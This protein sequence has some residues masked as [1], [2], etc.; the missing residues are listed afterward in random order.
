MNYTKAATALQ[1]TQPA[2]SQHIRYLEKEYGMKL[3]DYTGKRLALTEAGH[4]LLNAATT[5]SH[6]DTMLKQNLVDLKM[7]YKSLRFGVTHTIGESE[8]MEKLAGYLRQHPEMNLYMEIGDAADLL[9]A[10]NE[11]KIDF[12]VIEGFFDQSEYETLLFGTEVLTAVCHPDYEAPS[13][14]TVGE[15]LNKRIIL[16]EPGSGTRTLVEQVLA[17]QGVSVANFQQ[18]YEVGS[19]QAIKELA[20]RGC[21]IGFLF[22]QSVSKEISNGVLRRIHI[23]GCDGTH[24]STFIWRKG[25]MYSTMF[26]YIYDQLKS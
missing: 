4:I 25:S 14:M 19:P 5:I 18:R 26:R 23:Q 20:E 11:G 22:E 16:R 7:N 15:L 17:E 6:D 13:E 9:T 2:V 24:T 3:F 12:A 1:I 8:I 10:I 21:G